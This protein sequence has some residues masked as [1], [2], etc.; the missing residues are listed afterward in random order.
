MVPLPQV[1]APLQDLTVLTLGPA[2]WGRR[3]PH[4][5]WTGHEL[6]PSG[7]LALAPGTP[8][9]LRYGVRALG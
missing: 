2:P 7:C 9:Q 3:A 5:G 6:V 4:N 1:R 8:P